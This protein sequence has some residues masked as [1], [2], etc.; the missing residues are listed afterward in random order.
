LRK[1]PREGLTVTKNTV[2]CRRHFEDQFVIT[3]DFVGGMCVKRDRPKLTE[4]AYPSI[5]PNVP[6]YLST[7]VPPKR[8]N[9][10]DRRQLQE[11]REE[12]SFTEWMESDEICGFDVLSEKFQEHLVGHLDDWQCKVFR[13]NMCFYKID[14]AGT[15]SVTCCVLR[16]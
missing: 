14:F 3:E 4:D 8:T 11:R 5:F 6:D 12:Q 7:P 16:P 10:S 15:P 9:S 1:I 13:E 2:I